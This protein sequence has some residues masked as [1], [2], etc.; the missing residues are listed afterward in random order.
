MTDKQLFNSKSVN[1]YE[2]IVSQFKNTLMATNQDLFDSKSDKEYEQIV[3]EPAYT[4]QELQII[5][6]LS[7]AKKAL[8]TTTLKI[9]THVQLLAKAVCILG[10]LISKP[11]GIDCV[12]L[13]LDFLT[14]KELILIAAASDTLLSCFITPTNARGKTLRKWIKTKY[15]VEPNM[16]YLCSLESGQALRKELKLLTMA[17]NIDYDIDNFCTIP[18]SSVNLNAQ[19]NPVYPIVAVQNDELLYIMTYGGRIKKTHGQILFCIVKKSPNKY[20][21][22]SWNST[23]T[24]LLV[25]HTMYRNG[26]IVTFEICKIIFLIIKSIFFKHLLC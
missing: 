3:C 23:G 16:S 6:R 17:T 20:K 2:H 7:W 8:D 4:T 13:I 10:L 12:G 21:F 19:F 14:P 11:G 5:N 26:F 24:F 18:R 25:A 22:F 9:M 15:N 1:T